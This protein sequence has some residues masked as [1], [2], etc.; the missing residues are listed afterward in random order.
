MWFRNLFGFDEESP[1][2]VR[3]NIE[4]DGQLMVSK[5]NKARYQCG[6]LEIC[7]LA[8]LR[9]AL[10]AFGAIAA[11]DGERRLVVEQIVGDI[12]D[13]HCDPRNDGCVIQV[14]SQFNV[15]EM[16]SPRVTPEEGVDIYEHDRTQGPICAI[17]CGAGTVYRNYFVRFQDG[18]IGQTRDRQIDCLEDIGA[19]LEKERYN[20]WEMR[21]GYVLADDKGQQHINHMLERMSGEEIDMLRSRLKVGVQKD[22]EVTLGSCGNKITQVYCSALPIAYCTAGMDEWEPFARLILEAAY[23]AT[24]SVAVEKFL[25]KV[26]PSIKRETRG[27]LFLTLLG[28]GAFGNRESWAIDAIQRAAKLHQHYPMDVFIVRYS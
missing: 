1:E 16:V 26:D 24:F 14:A 21:N 13:V 19:V 23:E 2:Q 8:E 10:S 27:K 6:S 25:L 7:S 15:L 11:D 20:L 5:V 3:E 12:R 9:R 17:A 18:Q 22:T 28:C 4:V